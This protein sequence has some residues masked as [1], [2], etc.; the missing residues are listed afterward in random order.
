[1]WGIRLQTEAA[2]GKA[3]RSLHLQAM[4]LSLPAVLALGFLLGLRH[5]FEPD[6]LAAVSTLATRAGRLRD[7]ARLGVA[8][9][10]AWVLVEGFRPNKIFLDQF[11]IYIFAI[12]F[13]KNIMTFVNKR[14]EVCQFEMDQNESTEERSC[15][16][17]FSTLHSRDFRDIFAKR[18]QQF[19]KSNPALFFKYSPPLHS[20]LNFFTSKPTEKIPLA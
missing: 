17:S 9:A 19:R 14:H 16:E 1:M 3:R 20:F 4:V 5:A 15:G 8:W 6:H 13:L 12:S 7:A 2:Y 11:K 10:W 18:V